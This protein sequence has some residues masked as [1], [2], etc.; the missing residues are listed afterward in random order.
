MGV[1][2]AIEPVIEE[3]EEG[4]GSDPS[5]P[6]GEASS[7]EECGPDP[8]PINLEEGLRRPSSRGRPIASRGK[9]A[10][11]HDGDWRPQVRTAVRGGMYLAGRSSDRQPLATCPPLACLEDSA[12]ASQHVLDAWSGTD[13]PAAFGLH[14]SAE[15]TTDTEAFLPH[16]EP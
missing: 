8:M 5:A 16:P 7:A 11:S 4:L 10:V 15:E 9:L 13:P 3:H 12:L 2:G 1:E 6:S 14:E